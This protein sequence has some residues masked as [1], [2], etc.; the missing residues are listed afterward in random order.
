MRKDSIEDILFAMQQQNLVYNYNFLL[1][2]NR[3]IENTVLIY[4]HPDGWIYKD[5]GA[6]AEIG[7]DEGTN[8]CLIQKSTDNSKMTFSQFI[9]EFPRWKDMMSGEKI[10]ASFNIE[11]P[12]SAAT[13]FEI[14]FYLKD[15]ISTSSKI[16]PFESGSTK[17]IDL[18]LM[19]SKNAESVEIGLECSTSKA[20]IYVNKVFANIGE[21]ALETLPC[22]IQG[23]IGERKQYIATEFAPEKELSLCKEPI[24][25]T[26]KFTRLNSV[27][28]YRFGKGSGGNSMLI[29]MRG[30]FSRAWNNGANTD[31]DA[32]TRS[33]P[34]TGTIKGDHVSTFEDDIF[35]KHD[36]GLKFSTDLMITAGTGASMSIINT[37]ATSK[38][39]V[40]AQ[41]QETRPKNIAELYTIKWA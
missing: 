4:N 29:D 23:V 22:I 12:A 7:F 16:I 1:Y 40:E 27:L 30:Y 20:V 13:D 36:H 39:D 2:S 11:N 26:N 8:S 14:N 18:E 24:E 19:I 35:K 38:T 17:K 10:T 9:N 33:A 37:K 41:G 34:G 32:A 31:T 6:N 28:N 15:G 25:L 5:S 3:S 21:I